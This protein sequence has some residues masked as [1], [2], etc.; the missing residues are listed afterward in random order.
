VAIF[1]ANEKV[2]LT[3]NCVAD[4]FKVLKLRLF[5]RNFQK[6]PLKTPFPLLNS[7]GVKFL[8]TELPQLAEG[9]SGMLFENFISA[10]KTLSFCCE[11]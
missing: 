10:F 6:H 9:D 5:K 3:I 11:L 8:F 2:M 1:F 7:E 4:L